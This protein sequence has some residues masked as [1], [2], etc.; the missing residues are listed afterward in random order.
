MFFLFCTFW[1]LK[2]DEVLDLLERACDWI[3]TE[4]IDPGKGRLIDAARGE[5][6]HYN[7]AKRESNKL[8]AL[9]GISNGKDKPQTQGAEAR[10]SQSLP[11]VLLWSRLGSDRSCLVASAY[12][13]R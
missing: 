10:A 5:V 12:L 7:P 3:E 9:K 2:K 8:R 6:G 13:I 4:R 1:Q 11:R